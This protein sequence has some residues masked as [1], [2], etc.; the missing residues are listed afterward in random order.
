MSVQAAQMVRDEVRR[1]PNATLLLPTGG[2]PLGMYRELTRMHSQ[3]GLTFAEVTTFNLDE[4]VGLPPGHPGSYRR[5]MEENFFRHIDID[6]ANTHVLDGTGSN[7][8]KACLD[9]EQRIREAGGIDLA[10]LGIGHNGH[11]AFVEPPAAVRAWTHVAALARSTREA[12]ARFFHSLADVPRAALTVGLGTILGC[13]RVLLLASGIEKAD[14]VTR[15]I[16]GPVHAMCPGSALQLH[17]DVTVIM[18]QAAASRLQLRE[19]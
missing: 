11:V 7:L 13:R 12:K 16:E 17:P 14:A 15:A 5:Y 4:Y 2:T 9:Y 3:E 6:P 8:E 18:D 1:K 10:V 19:H